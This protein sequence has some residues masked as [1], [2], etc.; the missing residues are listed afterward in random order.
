M[1]VSHIFSIIII[2]ICLFSLLRIVSFIE[3]YS[4]DFYYITFLDNG[5][6]RLYIRKYQSLPNGKWQGFR[7]FIRRNH[8]N[9]RQ[10]VLYAYTCN[11][12]IG[13]ILYISKNNPSRKY[14]VLC[15]TIADAVFNGRRLC[16][17]RNCL[18]D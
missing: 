12:A 7:A 14:F 11:H 13:H 1:R 6:K 5:L 18:L 10:A 3:L 2:F 8:V 16:F 15:R 4:D 17:K 9:I